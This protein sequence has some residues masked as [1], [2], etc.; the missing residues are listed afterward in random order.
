[1]DTYDN[2][3]LTKWVSKLTHKQLLN[4]LSGDNTIS[5]CLCEHKYIKDKKLTYPE[6][7]NQKGYD[8]Y[9]N[10]GKKIELKFTNT[11]NSKKQFYKWNIENKETSDFITFYIRDINVSS[12]IPTK[13]FYKHIERYGIDGGTSK[14][15][16]LVSNEL[17]DYEVTSGR[18]I[19]K[20]TKKKVNRRY[21]N[22]KLF[23]KYKD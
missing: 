23:L 11:L 8:A 1:M 18:I 19:D 7:L 4:I 21:V 16:F 5:A 2:D 3:A 20:K 10:D 17:D 15:C 14:K 9:R 12:T 6:D 13:V 22:T